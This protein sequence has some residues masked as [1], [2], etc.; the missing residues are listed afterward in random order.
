MQQKQRGMDYVN[1]HLAPA[2]HQQNLHSSQLLT[3][4]AVDADIQLHGSV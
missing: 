1:S 2:Y 4:T 3:N